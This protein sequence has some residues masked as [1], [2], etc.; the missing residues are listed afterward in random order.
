MANIYIVRGIHWGVSGMPSK[1][2]MLKADADGEAAELVNL[3]RD[4][5]A[6]L[7]DQDD[8]PKE[9]EFA[10]RLGVLDPA[11][12]TASNWQAVLKK[13]QAKRAAWQ[14]E[15]LFDD[16]AA[17]L[18]GTHEIEND[19]EVWIEAM[20]VQE[21]GAGAPKIMTESVPCE[22][23]ARR[24]ET[25]PL[26]LKSLA[27]LMAT[28]EASTFFD[29]LA[30]LG[31]ETPMPDVVKEAAQRANQPHPGARKGGVLHA[32]GSPMW[33][34]LPVKTLPEAGSV[35]FT[36][37]A[38]KNPPA[39]PEDE[40]TAVGGGPVWVSP[41]GKAIVAIGQRDTAHFPISFN[42]GASVTAFHYDWDNTPIADWRTIMTGISPLYIDEDG[43]EW[44]VHHLSKP[45]TAWTTEGVEKAREQVRHAERSDLFDQI[46]L[47]YPG[48]S[49]GRITYIGERDQALR[50]AG[51]KG[52]E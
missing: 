32:D 45:E 12:A 18:L 44:L 46:A 48:G 28:A 17:F 11:E 47:T 7:F 41:T 10:K 49:A 6:R 19:C 15:E 36:Y 2:F 30:A 9:T 33:V 24:D 20:D 50:W 40:A 14:G 5:V 4:D 8:M 23:F 3:L 43:E 42:P 37:D 22:P 29:K 27:D 25:V 35:E 21:R 51:L 13:V 52:D 26:P 38:G 34:D 16:V 31:R 39:M 1:G